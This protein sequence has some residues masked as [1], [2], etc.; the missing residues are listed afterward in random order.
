VINGEEDKEDKWYG[1][2]VDKLLFVIDIQSGDIVQ[3]ARLDFTGAISAIL[4][5]GDEIFISLFDDTSEV[6]VCSSSRGPRR[7]GW[8]YCPDFTVY[9]PPSCP[10]HTVVSP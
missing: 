1:K 9:R 2:V 3:R 7:E 5:D 8:R 6:V 10:P 4:V